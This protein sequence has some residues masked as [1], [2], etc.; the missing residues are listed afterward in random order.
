MFFF[1]P[2]Y[3]YFPYDTDLANCCFTNSGPFQEHN[4]NKLSD[5]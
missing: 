2:L 4:F 5:K 3:L 1:S